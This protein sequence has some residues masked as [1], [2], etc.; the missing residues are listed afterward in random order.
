MILFYFL[1]GAPPNSASSNNFPLTCGFLIYFII[2]SVSQSTGYLSPTIFQEFRLM[3]KSIPALAL[4]LFIPVLLSCEGMTNFL[5]SDEQ[6]IEMG[7]KFKAQIDADTVNYPPYRGTTPNRTEVINYINAMG[8]NIV[9]AQNDRKIAF[10]FSIIVNT[11]INA[12]AIPGGHIYVNTGL[13][14]AAASGAEVAGVI[15][16]EIGHVTMRHGANQMMKA[17]AVGVVQQILFGT[18]TASISAAVTKM[19]TGLLFLKFSR[20]DENQADS[21]AVAYTVAA[22]YNPYGFKYFF[23]TL[24]ARYGSGLGPFEILSTHPNTDERINHTQ[25]LINK[26]PNVPSDTTWMQT[27]RYAEIK[28]KI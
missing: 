6:E 7:N 23:A 17:S 12:F 18:D 10:T 8:Q 25:A 22:R 28:Q 11:E 15:A 13:L 27:A 3:M 24:K 1:P 20:D 16:H 5:I 19:V 14:R 2:R 4:A 26:T 21:C 9:R